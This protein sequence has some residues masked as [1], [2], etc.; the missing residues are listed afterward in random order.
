MFSLVAFGMQEGPRVRWRAVHASGRLR[1]GQAA[2]GAHWRH[3]T[4]MRVWHK[5][6]LNMTM[7]GH[8]K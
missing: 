8:R 5:E 6:G 7:R 4:G 1:Q 3:G 2:T